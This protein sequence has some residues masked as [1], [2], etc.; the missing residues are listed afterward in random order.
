ID[1]TT[2]LVEAGLGWIVA[3][4]KGDFIG[5]T[6][7]EEQ[8]KNGAPRKLVGF[9]MVGRGIARHGYPV[10]LGGAETGHVTSGSFAP[11]LQKNIGLAY[12]PAARSAPGT[13]FEVEIRGKHVAARVV[14]TPFYK[15][16]K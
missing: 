2:T 15:R 13:E 7:L 10:F 12:L 8:K 14:P 3:L 6:V 16:R 5:R 1:E 9:E 4:E 11:F